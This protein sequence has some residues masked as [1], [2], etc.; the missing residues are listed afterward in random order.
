MKTISIIN[1]KGGVAKTTTTA[2]LSYEFTQNFGKKV[3]AI[4]LDPS[5]NL[6]RTLRKEGSQ[7]PDIT[8]ADILMGGADIESAVTETKYDNLH[9]IQAGQ[10]LEVVGKGLEAAN[11]AE[12]LRNV[13]QSQ[14]G[15]FDF[16]ILDNAPTF[17]KITENSLIA[18]DEVIVPMCIESYSLFGLGRLIQAIQDARKINPALYFLGVLIT[19]YQKNKDEDVQK[20]ESGIYSQSQFPVIPTK[21]RTSPKAVGSNINLKVVAE[22]SKR[23]SAAIDYHQVA[24]AYLEGRLREI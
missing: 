7:E 11:S 24:K 3:L 1:N 19:R 4:D 21:I 12:I 2:N 8:I 9:I 16:C 23:S 17:T 6:S 5:G 10:S 18:S 20:I 15:R 14:Q 13:L 22:T